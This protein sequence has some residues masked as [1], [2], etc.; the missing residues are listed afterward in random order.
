MGDLGDGKFPSE[1]KLNESRLGSTR[2]RKQHGLV[3]LAHAPQV[4]LLVRKRYPMFNQC[5]GSRNPG[6]KARGGR[7]AVLKGSPQTHSRPRFEWSSSAEPVLSSTPGVCPPL[8]IELIWCDAVWHRAQVPLEH[9][10]WNRATAQRWDLGGSWT[11]AMRSGALNPRALA[12]TF[13]SIAVPGFCLRERCATL[14]DHVSFVELGRGCDRRGFKCARRCDHPVDT[15][16]E[17][18]GP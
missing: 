5:F 1:T 17:A 14:M 11:F 10:D 9:C 7:Q 3:I 15:P 6:P 18:D 12:E 2:T 16:S 4:V 8:T 13:V